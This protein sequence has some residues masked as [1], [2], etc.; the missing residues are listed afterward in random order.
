MFCLSAHCLFLQALIDIC[1]DEGWLLSTLRVMNLVQMCTQGQWISD[2][3]LLTLPHLN[4]S[5]LSSLGMFSD[6][7]HPLNMECMSSLAEILS[8]YDKRKKEVT[9]KFADITK[10]RQHADNVCV[11]LYLFRVLAFIGIS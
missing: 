2:P 5:H 3:S 4:H 9:S 7:L 6:L 1:A 10:S 11:T 8:L